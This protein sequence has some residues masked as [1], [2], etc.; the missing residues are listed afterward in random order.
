MGKAL[1]NIARGMAAAGAACGLFGCDSGGQDSTPV[2]PVDGMSSESFQIVRSEFS[3]RIDSQTLQEIYDTPD[4]DLLYAATALLFQHYN[5]LQ[6]AQGAELTDNSYDLMYDWVEDGTVRQSSVRIV[7]ID[8]PAARENM[9]DT[10]NTLAT[11]ESDTDVDGSAVIV[12]NL[13]AD[14]NSN[15]VL[16]QVLVLHE[17]MHIVQYTE[18]LATLR[19]LGVEESQL[20]AELD[21]LLRV[22]DTEFPYRDEVRP[23]YET[24]SLVMRNL[25][26]N[27]VYDYFYAATTYTD[28]D[29][30]EQ[31]L[32]DQYNTRYSNGVYGDHLMNDIGFAKQV[33]EYL[34]FANSN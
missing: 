6:I 31:N 24:C 27:P 1:N 15:P 2:P 14:A 32:C 25:G 16:R 34:L 9:T 22:T 7:I 19:E 10:G 29:G 17:A 4:E 3:G 26:V 12:V 33:E 13:P 30:E 20:A 28:P 5:D 23:W 18:I 21:I 11:V 8:D